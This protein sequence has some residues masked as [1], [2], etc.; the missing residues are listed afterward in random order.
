MTNKRSAFAF[1]A[2]GLV[3]SSATAFDIIDE[4]E[5]KLSFNVDFAT[6]VFIGAD[7]WFD[8]SEAFLGAET[9]DWQE[10][11]VEPALLFETPAGKGK[12]SAQLSGVYTKTYGDDASGLTIG[13]DDP[14]ELTVEQAHIGW[15]VEDLFEG[16]DEDELS[17]VIGRQDYTIG[18]GMLVNDGGGDGGERGG[19][20]LGMRK[21]FQDALIVR[22]RSEA[23]LVEGFSLQNR[24]RSGGTQGDADGANLEYTLADVLTLGA[25]YMQVD[26]NLADSTTLDVFS[27]R[28]DWE[29]EVGLLLGAEYAQEDSD[30]IGA[31]GWY[32][33]I[34]YAAEDA[35]WAPVF[36]YRYAH[37]DGDDPA[38]TG[39]E[40][41]REIA[42]GY[43]DYGSWYQG[44]ITGNYLL[45]NGNVISQQLRVQLQ[46][47]ENLAV[48]ALY[49]R[50]T[51]DQPAS[52]AA[53]VT[54]DDFGDELN[55]AFDW[56]ANEKIHLIGVIGAVFPGD[57]AEQWVG[58]GQDWLY[59]MLYVS[60]SL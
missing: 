24:P 32:G 57:A 25:T 1:F 34:G 39:D 31:D 30:E 18:T 15:S 7:S 52:L 17:V 41:F 27:A 5:T 37:F 4:G 19:W 8:Q 59:S 60:Y 51:L 44:E 42:Y 12:F 14:D 48:N 28:V 2:S 38:T 16:L 20:Y 45:G 10:V 55:V 35:S 11:G 56:D 26:A 49:Y 3:A 40:R 9:D 21:A 53:G 47:R 6:A 13:L 22:L 46:P 58:G 23:W 33:L 50:F 54:N 43:T 29:S 36:S